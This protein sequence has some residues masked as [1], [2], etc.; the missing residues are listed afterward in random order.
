[1][2][3]ATDSAIETVYVRLLDEGVEVWRPVPA[4][5]LGAGAFQLSEDS[6]PEEVWEFPPGSSVLASP[7]KLSEG[8]RL[9]AV[10]ALDFPSKNRKQKPASVPSR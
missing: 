3:A 4:V 9:V 2:S 10:E 5:A 8:V 7:Q 1:M 6:A